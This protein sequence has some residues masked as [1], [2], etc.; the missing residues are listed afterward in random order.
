MEGI[1]IT[2]DNSHISSEKMTAIKASPKLHK[3]LRKITQK[4]NHRKKY[5]NS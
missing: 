2:T 5:K 1:A 3:F 4:K